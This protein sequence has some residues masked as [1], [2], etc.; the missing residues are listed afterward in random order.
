MSGYDN[1][2]RLAYKAFYD[3]LLRNMCDALGIP[4]EDLEEEISMLQDTGP[5]ES[6]SPDALRLCAWTERCTPGDRAVAIRLTKLRHEDALY[7]RISRSK[8]A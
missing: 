1:D 7:G 5:K 8:P 3:R 6:L 4:C 2:F